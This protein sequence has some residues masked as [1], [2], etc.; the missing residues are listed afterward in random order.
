[1]ISEH[2]EAGDF[3]IQVV[4]A[5]HPLFR[6]RVRDIIYEVE[7]PILDMLIGSELKIPYFTGPLKAKI[8]PL[9]DLANTFN[10]RGKGVNNDM[11]RGRPD[12]TTTGCNA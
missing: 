1:M 7:I 9:S 8:P 11:G 10:L 6:L 5:R 12:N 3:H 2:G 4:I